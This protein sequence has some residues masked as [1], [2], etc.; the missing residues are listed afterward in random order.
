VV[1]SVELNLVRT[2]QAELDTRSLAE[3]WQEQLWSALA[4]DGDGFASDGKRNAPSRTD[5]ALHVLALPWK[6]CAVAVPPT[7]YRGGVPAFF[8]TLVLIGLCT[9]LISDMASILGCTLGIS[10]PIT[11]ITLVAVGTSVPDTFA[12]RIAA[13]SEPTADASLTNVMGSN[14]ANVFLG[15]GLPWTMAALYWALVGPT[16]A[17]T[18]RY[19]DVA[20][21]VPEHTA[22][23]VVQ[24]GDLGFSVAL[25]FV[26]CGF[27]VA[28]LM[29]RRFYLGAELG[30]ERELNVRS[31]LAFVGIWVVFTAIVCLKFAGAF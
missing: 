6:L 4:L 14:S 2:A 22:A 20:A 10:D 7:S 31:A 15:L 27:G 30:G 11:A 3:A 23:Y 17:W 25:F 9:T 16:E 18:A 13:I 8:A 28:I 19:P 29:W 12:S 26:A 1:A 24:G 5:V 21:S